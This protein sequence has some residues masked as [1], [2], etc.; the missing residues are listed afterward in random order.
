MAFDLVTFGIFVGLAAGVCT[1]FSYFDRSYNPIN[2]NMKNLFIWGKNLNYL[3]IKEICQTFIDLFDRIYSGKNVKYTTVARY[4]WIGI[5]IYLGF[6]VSLPILGLFSHILMYIDNPFSSTSSGTSISLVMIEL[7]APAVILFYVICFKIFEYIIPK[8]NC[9]YNRQF[10]SPSNCRNI[11]SKSDGKSECSKS[12]L[13][14]CLFMS[15]CLASSVGTSMII[16]G[17]LVK[18]LSPLLVQG[19]IPDIIDVSHISKLA[20]FGAYEKFDYLNLSGLLGYL[21]FCLQFFIIFHGY[22]YIEYYLFVILLSV[23]VSIV[24]FVSSIYIYAILF[25]MGKYKSYF[26]I[27]PLRVIL[28]SVFFIILFSLLKKELVTPFLAS[29]DLFSAFSMYL[30]LNILTDS[31]SILETRYMLDKA[32]S[33]SSQKLILF[34]FLDIVASCLIYIL[35]PTINRDFS[36]FL[37]AIFFKGDM[38]WVGIFFWSSMFTSLFFYLYVFCFFI[39]ITLYKCSSFKFLADRPIYSLGWII[40]AALIIIIYPIY[41]FWDTIISNIIF[42]IIFSFSVFCIIYK[43]VL[44][45]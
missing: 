28:S 5:F 35:I 20:S 37:D 31:I 44:K 4:I 17:I 30:L 34:L 21:L 42:L 36:L 23:M 24:V 25:F 38:A 12:S 15:I 18:L 13:T 39:L 41:M 14:K 45:N 3:I 8:F 26:N 33:G 29:Y 11:T 27:S 16:I 40:A 43:M 7:W 2:E 6:A 10:F 22:M 9:L 32:L 1:I 19:G